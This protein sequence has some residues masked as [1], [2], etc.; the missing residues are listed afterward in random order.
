MR[1]TV[2]SA[3]FVL[4]GYLCLRRTDNRFEMPH[5][6]Q[7]QNVDAQFG[8]ATC[9]Q[10]FFRKLSGKQFRGFG[11]RKERSKAPSLSG[12]AGE[13][14]CFRYGASNRLAWKLA[15]FRDKVKR[16][17]TSGEFLGVPISR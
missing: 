4:R 15:G 16:R 3:R 7:R 8:R 2:V 11:K 17:Q 9:L 1:R 6:F 5:V 10:G 12:G 14:A 13:K